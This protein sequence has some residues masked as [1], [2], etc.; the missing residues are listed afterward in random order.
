MYSS[1][2][3][4][5]YG[6]EAPGLA[7]SMPPVPPPISRSPSITF[8]PS[9]VTGCASALPD[10]PPRKS[11]E[12]VTE[13]AGA[14]SDTDASML[15]SYVIDRLSTMP[16]REEVMPPSRDKDSKLSILSYGNLPFRN[17]THRCTILIVFRASI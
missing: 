11:A 12:P 7:S 8:P 13:G 10:I 9:P 4:K 6:C 5:R 2:P 15:P 14:E 17:T 1:L 3:R 16:L